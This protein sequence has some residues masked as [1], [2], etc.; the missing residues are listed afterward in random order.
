MKG[1]KQERKNEISPRDREKKKDEGRRTK[2][3]KREKER[4]DSSPLNLLCVP[5]V[6]FFA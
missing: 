1:E 4:R 5:N 6:A 3:K 2:M